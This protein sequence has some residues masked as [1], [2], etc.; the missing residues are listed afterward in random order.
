M[1][2]RKAIIAATLASSAAVATHDNYCV[3][4]QFPILSIHA[5]CEPAI[6]WFNPAYC[7]L[8]VIK[9]GNTQ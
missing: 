2:L 6:S 5:I 1:I 8:C 4:V 7:T 3:A 9:R